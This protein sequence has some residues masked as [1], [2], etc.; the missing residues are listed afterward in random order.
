MEPTTFLPIGLG[1]IVIGADLGI[2]KWRKMELKTPKGCH[3]TPL[4]DHN[5]TFRMRS[6]LP[7][8]SLLRSGWMDGRELFSL[9][10]PI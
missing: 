1:L 7:I 6:Q 10:L 4:Q 2:G 8:V 3:G 9:D 5:S